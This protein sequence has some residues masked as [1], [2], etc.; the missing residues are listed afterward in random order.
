M[1]ICEMPWALLTFPT[2]SMCFYNE[3][4]CHELQL[5]VCVNRRVYKKIYLGIWQKNTNNYGVSSQFVSF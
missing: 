2:E 5:K 3:L 4:T 1:A